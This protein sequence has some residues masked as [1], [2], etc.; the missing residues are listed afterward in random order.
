M[1]ELCP[2]AASECECVS[3]LR[4]RGWE[5]RAYVVVKVVLQVVV[6]GIR[7]L[8]Q[9]LLSADDFKRQSTP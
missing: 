9:V 1:E 7:A 8:D 3:S 2:G 5:W 6:I 4:V